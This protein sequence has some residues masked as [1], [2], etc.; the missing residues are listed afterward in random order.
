MSP[1]PRRRP[2]AAS[3][4]SL[5]QT[6]APRSRGASCCRRTRSSRP[7]RRFRSPCQCSAAG[8]PRRGPGV[9]LL[10]H[11][12]H[13]LRRRAHPLPQANAAAPRTAAAPQPWRP[14]AAPRRL[15]RAQAASPMQRRHPLLPRL[16]RRS[17]CRSQLG[18]PEDRRAAAS[19]RPRG[20]LEL[21]AAPGPASPAAPCPA[22]AADLARPCLGP[23]SSSLSSWPW[24]RTSTA[25]S[26]PP[27]SGASPACRDSRAATRSGGR[28]TGSAA[29]TEAA[30][31]R[32]AW[33]ELPLPPC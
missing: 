7:R 5:P 20:S 9:G 13:P 17:R 11:R 12:A 10:R 14:R 3:G 31:R 22:A 32:R 26:A 29:Q 6:C 24:T 25:C 2:V 21:P 16:S 1:S 28:P 30:T 23:S 18:L 8:T 27:S 33:T 4:R 19:A 15:P